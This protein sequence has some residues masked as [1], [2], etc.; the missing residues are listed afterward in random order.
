MPVTSAKR[1]AQ[2]R[3]LASSVLRGDCSVACR[4]TLLE[5]V[6]RNQDPPALRKE[7]LCTLRE[8]LLD[9]LEA[10]P[11]DLVLVPTLPPASSR[12]TRRSLSHP[13]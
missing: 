3:F 6:R 9:C 5:P 13:L 10:L 12:D 4:M 7:L 1:D 2:V 8:S 11:A